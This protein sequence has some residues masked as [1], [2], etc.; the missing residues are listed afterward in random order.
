MQLII[1]GVAVEARAGQSL[2][3][4]LSENGMDTESLATRPLAADMA[5]ELFTL[6]FIP[7]PL[8]GKRE[9]SGRTRQSV[10]KSGGKI[11]L[12]RYSDERGVRL[13]ERGLLFMFLVALRRVFP[14]AQANVHHAIGPGIFISIKKTLELCCEDVAIIK[15]ECRRLVGEDLPFLR[16]R[17]D[18]Q[19]AIDY[20]AEDGQADK[21]EIL[22][23]RLLPYFDIYTCGGYTD[24]LYG[25][26]PPSTGYLSVFDMIF[27]GSGLT[28]LRPSAQNPN[29]PAP[30][31]PSPKFAGVFWESDRWGKLMNCDNV[32][33]LNR[34][35]AG[36][37][38]RE[39]IRVNEALHAKRFA[40]LAEDIARRGCRLVL[41]SGP[42]SSGKT[43]SANRLCTQL[44]V[45]GKTP[46]PLSLDDYYIDRDKIFPDENGRIDLEHINTIDVAQFREDMSRILRGE[47]VETPLFSFVTA[48]REKE[49]KRI[50]LEEDTIIVVEGL[51]A[52]NPQ[53]LPDIDIALVYRLY[54]SA[55]TTLNLD[56]HNRIPTTDVRLLRRMVR[57]YA[58][59]GASVERT[60]LMWDSVRAGEAQWV[61]PYQ[62]EADAIFNTAL[63][64]E[65][66]VLKG[67]IY[68]LL[69]SVQT[70]SPCYDEVQSIC[71]F[72]NY[73]PSAG[74]EAADEIPPTGI[75][76]EFI[77]GNTY[78]K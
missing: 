74:A 39:L 6:R 36:G 8:S 72:L 57:D 64:Y 43:T 73:I 42:S 69:R 70:E 32:A 55:L 17:M 23:W 41:L 76:R 26:M 59:R 49:G 21:A 2:C 34:I 3:E 19:D 30:Y 53:M 52:L 13:Y 62:E 50:L 63:V 29:L 7:L 14:E 9:G 78:Y 71:K 28:L 46:V 40:E 47:E 1:D 35:M 48:K 25:E 68:P 65:L 61:F 24:Y 56:N 66:A 20:F 77:G 38:L 16:R 33:D 75:L 67:F 10:A 51:H 12:V 15:E 11:K 37:K 60:L 45:L 4:I 18:L 58:T 5:G 22:Q 44:R 54:V 31:I 27:S